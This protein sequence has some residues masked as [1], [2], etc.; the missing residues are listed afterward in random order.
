MT[1]RGKQ[2]IRTDHP[3][4]LIYNLIIVDCEPGMGFNLIQWHSLIRIEH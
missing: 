1:E 3:T 2:V 4:F